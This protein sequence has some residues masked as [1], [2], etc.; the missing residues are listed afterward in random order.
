MMTDWLLALT[1]IAA[2]LVLMVG[3]RWGA[4]R[5]G[6]A[7]WFAA[8][9]IAVLR[10]GATL[11]LLAFA[12]VKALLLTVD[13]LYIIWTAL[14]LFKV[15]E[16]AGAVEAIGGALRRLTADRGMQALLLGWAFASFLQGV[17]G[18]GVPIAVIAPLMIG[19][20][21]TPLAAGLAVGWPGWRWG[22]CW[23]AGIGATPSRTPVP[24]SFG[25]T[26]GQVCRG[27]SAGPGAGK[28]PPRGRCCWPWRG[29]RFWW[30]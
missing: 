6:P 22:F 3:Y 2:I 1:P 20:G 28:R 15:A 19:L 10:F 25:R 24:V 27:P 14:L 26:P 18:F 12:Q 29:T 11:D 17:G 23:P 30:R 16:E 13:V 8:V 21:F 9:L 4:S 7:G 5:A